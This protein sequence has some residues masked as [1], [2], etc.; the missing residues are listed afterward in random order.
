MLGL[1]GASEPL[2]VNVEDDAVLART[3]FERGHTCTLALECGKRKRRK[4]HPSATTF[5]KSSQ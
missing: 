5:P 1:Q 2:S 3:I 4:L